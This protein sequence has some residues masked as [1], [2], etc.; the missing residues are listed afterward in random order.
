MGANEGDGLLARPIEQGIYFHQPATFLERRQRGAGPLGRLI[1]AKAGD[2]GGCTVKCT[3]QRLDFADGAA[4]KPSRD[5]RAHAVDA[6]PGD[7]SFDA[8]PV[9]RERRDPGA[10]TALSRRPDIVRLRKQTPSV[11]RRYVDRQP[12]RKKRV[13]NRLILEPKARGQNDGPADAGTNCGKAFEQV[14]T[15]ELSRQLGGDRPQACGRVCSVPRATVI[16]RQT[17][18]L[19]RKRG[20]KLIMQQRNIPA[21]Q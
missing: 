18:K 1:G 11:Q 12:L 16:I 6:L 7:Q 2:P 15:A 8:S 3:G 13:R 9:W 14:E 10:V 4:F 19:R 21:A 5:R 17:L 20:R